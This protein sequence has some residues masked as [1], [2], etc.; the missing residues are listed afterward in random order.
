[1]RV[2]F[3]LDELY[4]AYSEAIAEEL[5]VEHDIDLE[6]AKR[7]VDARIKESF[8]NNASIYD[9]LEPCEVAE[10]IALYRGDFS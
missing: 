5:N 9:H 10:T 4:E 6:S 7:L 2:K 8:F 3:T 1:M